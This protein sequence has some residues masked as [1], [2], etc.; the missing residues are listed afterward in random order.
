MATTILNLKN[1]SRIGDSITSGRPVPAQVNMFSMN[2]MADNIFLYS[3]TIEPRLSDDPFFP[4]M[5]L[6]KNRKTIKELLA[7]DDFIS[8]GYILYAMGANPND[9]VAHSVEAGTETISVSLRKV[10]SIMNAS[11]EEKHMVYSIILKWA[12]EKLR[13]GKLGPYQFD[14]KEHIRVSDNELIPGYYV[15]SVRYKDQ[16]CL[17]VDNKHR[18]M[19]RTFANALFHSMEQVAFEQRMVGAVICTSHG[20]HQ[21]LYRVV[22]VDWTKNANSTFHND[23][24]DK[25]ISY[26]DY[27]Q[28]TYNKKILQPH[29]PLLRCEARRNKIVDFPL[30]MCQ[31]TGLDDSIRNNMAQRREISNY[32]RMPTKDRLTKSK[33]FVRRLLSDKDAVNVLKQ[34]NVEISPEFIQVEGRELASYSDAIQVRNSPMDFSNPNNRKTLNNRYEIDLP[35]ICGYEK[36]SDNVFSKPWVFLSCKSTNRDVCNMF[37]SIIT[38]VCKQGNIA[39]CPPMLDFQYD[40]SERNT[41]FLFEQI[42]NEIT[43]TERRPA[44]VVAFIPSSK[45]V[46]L[47]ALL[48]KFLYENEIP[49]QFLKGNYKSESACSNILYRTARQIIAKTSGCIWSVNLNLR[50]KEAIIGIDVQKINGKYFASI[51]AT[52]DDFGI[53]HIHQIYCVPDKNNVDV[54]LHDFLDQYLA[55]MDRNRLIILRKDV[56]EKQRNSVTLREYEA[57]KDIMKKHKKDVDVTYLICNTTVNHKFILNNGTDPKPLTVFEGQSSST[58]GEGDDFISQFFITHQTV[59]KATLTPTQYVLMANTKI[60]TDA[61]TLNRIVDIIRA[62]SCNYQNWYGPIRIPDV[63]MYCRKFL[64]HAEVIDMGRNAAVNQRIGIN[65]GTHMSFLKYAL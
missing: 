15:R 49:S 17:Q 62:S 43:H 42:K 39:F 10:N 54:V 47:Y 16:L 33:N 41:P 58:G 13:F 19:Q 21:T 12:V 27:F 40:D 32:T 22:Q 29:L 34:Y 3:V 61:P 57:V 8:N 6:N 60:V 45:H 30:E 37:K 44:F 24:E 28:R 56:Q 46:T 20:T 4:K 5:L 18:L 35:F 9:F 1:I 23:K 31:L 2:S 51:V 63:L 48:K 7:C 11:A 59:A 14:M 64:S 25:E 52:T 38:D 65:I 26:V 36:P 50:T 53:N 55:N